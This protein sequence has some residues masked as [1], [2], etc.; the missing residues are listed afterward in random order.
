[1]TPF[2]VPFSV[3]DDLPRSTVILLSRVTIPPLVQKI[4]EYAYHPKP[5]IPPSLLDEIRTFDECYHLI[6]SYDREAIERCIQRC[7]QTDP[8]V[9]GLLRSKSYL[10][11][12]MRMHEGEQKAR[13]SRTVSPKPRCG[14]PLGRAG[15]LRADG[16]FMP[17]ESLPVRFGKSGL[18]TRG[19]RMA[20]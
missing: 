3:Q 4:L 11:D 6:T 10:V 12:H 8:H 20:P 17:Y 14:Y 5:V 19:W 13:Y 1:M 9:K 7:I 18:S 15:C 16:N 2:I